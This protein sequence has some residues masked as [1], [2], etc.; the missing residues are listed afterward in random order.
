MENRSADMTQLAELEIQIER[1][2][3]DHFPGWVE[4]TFSDASGRR[5]HIR[6]KVPVV[7]ESNL[8][9]SSTYPQSATIA[10]EVISQHFGSNGALIVEIDTEQP[11]HVESVEG[12]RR[13]KVSGDIIQFREGQ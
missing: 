7:S 9:E 5:W 1:F 10:C 11:W 13:F 3:D 6:E 12:E 2:V 8:D 4:C